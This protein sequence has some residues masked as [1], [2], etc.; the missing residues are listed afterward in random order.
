MKKILYLHQYFNFPSGNGSTRSYDLSKKFIEEGHQVTFITSSAF[1]TGDFNKRWTIIKQDNL[2]LHVLKSNYNNKLKF[3]K[4]IVEFIRFMVF[5]SLRSLKI[6]ADVVVATSTPLS[7]GIPAL[8]KKIFSGIPYIFEVRDVWPDVPIAMGIIKNRL[9]IYLLTKF[10]KLFYKKAI[11]IVAL[12]TDMSKSIQNKGIAK[13]KI[14]IIPNI[15]DLNKFENYKSNSILKE[16][17][18]DSD[19][20]RIVLYAGTIGYVNGLSYMVEL[21]KEF[22]KEIG[23]NIVFVIVGSGVEKNKIYDLAIEYKVYKDNLYILEPV[24][25][26]KLPFLYKECT[27]ACSFVLNIPELWAN[28]ANKYFDALAASRPIIINHLGWQADEIKKD[29]I[30]IVLDILPENGAIQLKEYFNNEKALKEHAQN[31]KK[32]AGKYTLEIAAKKYLSIFNEI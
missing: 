6:K 13:E 18:I 16:N 29:K 32:I 31:A 9:I 4:R 25:K 12:S 7:I 3:R 21:A 11:R 14:I 30:G 23:N 20:N 28:S 24:A 27:V 8:F 26:E 1:L 19:R 17:G 5:A 15:S 2:L 22:K 10:E